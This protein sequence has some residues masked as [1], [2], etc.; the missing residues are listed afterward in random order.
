[1]SESLRITLVQA[2]TVWHDAAANRA[3]ISA[4]LAE[5]RGRTDVVILPETFT[6]GFSNEAVASAERMD[7]ESV[8]WMRQQA[9]SLDAALTG[10]I[11]IRDGASVFNRLVWA[12]PDGVVQH[13]D[14][15]HL[16]RMAR[17]HERY[18]SG[19]ARLVVEFRGWRICP[20]VCYDLRFPVFSRNRADAARESGP[21]GGLEYDLLIYV[22]NWPAPRHEHWSTL[23]RAR[24]IE[25][26]CCVAGVNRAGTDGNGHSYVGGSAVIDA[27]G[28]TVAECAAAAQLAEATVS[29]EVLLAH[30]KRFPAHLDA[31]AFTIEG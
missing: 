9:T 1:M 14:K 24:A 10:S 12:T 29:R 21:E 15:R 5:H 20:L 6:T 11:Q 7:G 16:F 27:L 18:A 31:D 2:D 22:A 28:T 19:A 3:R 25:N 26:L 30:R 23:L 17:E 13:Y 8:A 4:Q